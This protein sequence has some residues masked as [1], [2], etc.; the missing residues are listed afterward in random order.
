MARLAQCTVRE[1]KL[2]QFFC[3]VDAPQPAWLLTP[4]AF[5]A[6]GCEAALQKVLGHSTL[7][8]TRRCAN[9]T[10]ADLQAIH[11]QVSFLTP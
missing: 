8:M 2:A 3:F 7:E 4:S 10:T 5:D 1:H 9:L 6:P 11:K